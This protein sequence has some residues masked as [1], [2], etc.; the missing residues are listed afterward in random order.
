MPRAM[1]NLMPHLLPEV[2]PLIAQ[3][4]VDY[5]RQPRKRAEPERR[6]MAAGN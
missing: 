5:L 6:K 3:P 2:V 1:G 4:L